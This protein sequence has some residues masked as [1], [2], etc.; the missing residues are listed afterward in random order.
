MRWNPASPTNHQYA[1]AVN[2]ANHISNNMYKILGYL[3][4]LEMIL[5][6]DIPIYG[7]E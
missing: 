2:C 5:Y 3:D 6:F 4:E 1:T 7:V